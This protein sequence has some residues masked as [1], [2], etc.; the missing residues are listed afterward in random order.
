MEDITLGQNTSD[1][2]IKEHESL[3]GKTKPRRRYSDSYKRQIV[4]IYSTF[5]V[6]GEKGAFLRKEGLTSQLV[7][8]WYREISSGKMDQVQKKRQKVQNYE[9]ERLNAKIER[10]EDLNLRFKKALKI[11]GKAL[12]LL[13]KLA[14]ESQD[15]QSQK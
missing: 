1:S 15:T 5:T 6:P 2:Q 13:G 8:R 7:N 4:E 3:S 14:A 10:L 12:E 9:V 11:Q